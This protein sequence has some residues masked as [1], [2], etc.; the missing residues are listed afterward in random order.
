MADLAGEQQAKDHTMTKADLVEQVTRVTELPLYIDRA[1]TLLQE[2]AGI[3]MP[4]VM[5]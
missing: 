1:L 5:G 3:R 2:Q 4:Q